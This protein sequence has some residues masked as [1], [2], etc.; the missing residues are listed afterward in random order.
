MR[1][2]FAGALAIVTLVAASLVWFTTPGRAADGD[3]SGT[4]TSA[5]GPEEGGVGH[6]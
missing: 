3:I 4:I 5:A 1:T 6:R 2:R